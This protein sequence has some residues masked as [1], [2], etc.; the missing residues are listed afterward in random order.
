[1]KRD[2]YFSQHYRRDK[3]IDMSLTIDCICSGKK[4]LDEKSSK[5]KSRKM[6]KKGELIVIWKAQG[7]DV[8]VITAF[9]N[10]RN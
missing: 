6:Y 8:F 3:N 9:W 2:F 1:M 5:Y 4:E 7:S 10:V